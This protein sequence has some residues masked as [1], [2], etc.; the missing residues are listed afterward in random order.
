MGVGEAGRRRMS[1]WGGADDGDYDAEM[2]Q[3]HYDGMFY[4]EGCVPNLPT[5]IHPN[6]PLYHPNHEFRCLKDPTMNSVA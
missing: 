6:P 2:N 5:Q 1:A 3:F 4:G